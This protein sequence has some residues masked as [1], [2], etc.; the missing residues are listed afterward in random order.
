MNEEWI[1]ERTRIISEMLDNPDQYGIYRTTKCFVEL[2]A[3]HE[4]LSHCVAEQEESDNNSCPDCGMWAELHKIIPSKP[5]NY[6]GN[7]GRRLTRGGRA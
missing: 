1:K 7:C 5:V 6:C 4:R 2:D 3:L